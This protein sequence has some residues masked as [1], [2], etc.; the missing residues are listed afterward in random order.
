MSNLYNYLFHYNEYTGLW[1]AF[2]REEQQE[3]MASMHPSE[4]SKALFNSDFNALID[5]IKISEESR[6]QDK[7]V[8]EQYGLQTPQ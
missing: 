8:Y 3:Y 5:M 4:E 6:E 1:A 7:T 2:R